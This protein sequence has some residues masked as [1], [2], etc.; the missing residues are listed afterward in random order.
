MCSGTA[1]HHLPTCWAEPEASISQNHEQ[2]SGAEK[3]GEAQRE[4]SELRVRV[5]PS[6]ARDAAEAPQQV[7]VQPGPDTDTRIRLL[8]GS[9]GGRSPA[10]G[11]GVN[12]VAPVRGAQAALPPGHGSAQISEVKVRQS[13][14]IVVVH[15]SFQ[16]L[17][18]TVDV[19]VQEIRR[20]RRDRNKD[21]TLHAAH[22]S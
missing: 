3:G 14:K 10:V 16:Q 11:D 15:F 19:H 13:R 20:I 6:V 4:V 12:K 22:C 18:R 7:G 2:K 21:A 8:P 5:I 17:V 1:V 9:W